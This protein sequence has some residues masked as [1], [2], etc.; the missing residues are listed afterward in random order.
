[1]AIQDWDWR[2][3]VELQD[4]SWDCAAASTAWALNAIGRTTTEAEVVASMYPSYISPTYGLLD[5]SG[6]GLV[7]W[8]GYQGVSADYNPNATWQDMLD[9]A[10]YQPMLMGGRGWCHWVGV[11]I[12]SLWFP[13][14]V[15]P[16]LALANPSPGWMGVKQVI[17]EDQFRQ[18]GA[19]SAVWFT[20]W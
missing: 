16:A 8:L 3:P 17:T 14:L 20:G 1:M 10:G 11:R 2:Q 18:L 7:E 13:S 9:A 19:F 5:A 6:A 4:V 15:T 12:S